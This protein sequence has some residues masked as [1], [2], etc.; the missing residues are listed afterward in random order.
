MN[1]LDLSPDV[2]FIFLLSYKSLEWV[3][4]VKN[5]M[6]RHDRYIMPTFYAALCKNL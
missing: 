1:A 5:W 2:I 6:N 3:G 4:N